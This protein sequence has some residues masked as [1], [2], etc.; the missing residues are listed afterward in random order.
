[1][2]GA[3]DTLPFEALLTSASDAAADKIWFLNTTSECLIFEC[4]QWV[5]S[6]H[7]WWQP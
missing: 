7:W 1:V 6:C 3:A 2:W 4:P 5:D